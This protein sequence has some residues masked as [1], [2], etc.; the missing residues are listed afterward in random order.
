M[1]GTERSVKP[2]IC[3]ECRY[4]VDPEKDDVAHLDGWDFAHERC[5]EPGTEDSGRD[6]DAE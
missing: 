3:P 5:V 4:K 1:S 2:G 6:N